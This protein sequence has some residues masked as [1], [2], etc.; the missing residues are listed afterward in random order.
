[1]FIFDLFKINL[2]KIFFNKKKTINVI[3]AFG[4][5]FVLIFTINF[6]IDGLIG[7]Y[8]EKVEAGTNGGVVI[9]AKQK[10]V[11]NQDNSNDAVARQ[12]IINDIKKH[13]GKILKNVKTIGFFQLPVIE[14]KI[15]KNLIEISIE[16]LPK[17]TIPVIA[18]TSFGEQLLGEHSER[19]EKAKKASDYQKFRERLVGKTFV[20][21]YG[22]KYF[23]AGLNRGGYHTGSLSF[24]ELEGIDTTIFNLFLEK[25]NTPEVSTIAIDNGNTASWQIGKSIESMYSGILGDNS[26]KIK[27]NTP[28]YAY[29]SNRSLAYNFFKNSNGEFSEMSSQ[30][31]N[32]YLIN[33]I[34]GL[35]PVQIFLFN[36]LR[37]IVRIISIILLVIASIIIVSTNTR[38]VLQD[39]EEI[40]LYYSLGASSRQ[41]KQIYIIRF[42][43]LIFMSLLAAFMITLLGLFIFHL[44][45]GN[46]INNIYT[47]SFSLKQTPNVSWLGFSYFDLLVILFTLLLAPLSVYLNSK[48]LSRHV[49]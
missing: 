46:L 16:N 49:V 25:I 22:A 34:L 33:L 24:A 23:I 44:Y 43:I 13:N 11:S 1:M 47:L 39:K 28:I 29:F 30:D 36:I 17:D 41:I 4:S 21:E 18:S 5:I 9:S 37:T 8:I 7:S 48:N 3:V 32:K 31:N 10:D 40:S 27:N 15:V 35:S 6:F 26:K 2:K 12:K 14:Q 45:R 19:I 38:L 20:D 42:L